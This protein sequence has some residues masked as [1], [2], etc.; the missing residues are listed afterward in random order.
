MCGIENEKTRK[1]GMI[2]IIAM[3]V[4][5]IGVVIYTVVSS[6]NF[7]LTGTK[8]SLNILTILEYFLIIINA[9]MCIIG[10][11]GF[12]L[13]S[14]GLIIYYTIVQCIVFIIG[15]LIT[16][17]FIAIGIQGEQSP[18]LTQYSLCYNI[19]SN[20]TTSL[21]TSIINPNNYT[22]AVDN[23]ITKVDQLFCSAECPCGYTGQNNVP[24]R[25]LITTTSGPTSFKNCPQNVINN[26]E[27]YS[28]NM[29][30]TE[31]FD[32][33]G[34][35]LNWLETSF[36]CTGFCTTNYT[37]S[38][39]LTVSL[40][41]YLFSNI[42]SPKSTKKSCM[43]AIIGWIIY[44]CLVLGILD[45]F[46]LIIGLLLVIEGYMF[47]Y[48]FIDA[49]PDPENYGKIVMT[50]TQGQ[51]AN[52]E[53]RPKHVPKFKND[54]QSDNVKNLEMYSTKENNK[55]QNRQDKYMEKS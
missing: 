23:Y 24:N 40:D 39:G 9:I 15:L 37:D 2:T 53:E 8:V 16:A 31:P 17:T 52:P 11:L 26:A 4:L 13:M 28:K 46:V 19:T 36:S 20:N 43:Q 7:Q 38:T 55:G 18:R 51:I 33:L 50:Q 21:N 12:Y 34:V 49:E 5:M 30:F 29:G 1:I 27:N 10:F 48:N 54:L 42:N 14:K 25:T 47:W 41:R 22:F 32:Q 44:F 6:L 3:V 35:T 45:I